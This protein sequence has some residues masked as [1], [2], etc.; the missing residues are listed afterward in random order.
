[1][2]DI[3]IGVNNDLPFYINFGINIYALK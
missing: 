2:V 1:L 3:L